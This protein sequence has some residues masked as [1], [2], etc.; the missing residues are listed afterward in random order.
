M[1]NLHAYYPQ[2]GFDSNV[3]Y[4]SQVHIEALKR[5]GPCPIHTDELPY[6]DT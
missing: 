3:G 4:G 5:L 6:G 2:Y 1:E